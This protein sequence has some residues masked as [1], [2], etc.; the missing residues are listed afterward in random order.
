MRGPDCQHCGSWLPSSW[1][2][3]NFLSRTKTGVPSLS[4]HIVERRLSHEPCIQKH[5]GVGNKWMAGDNTVAQVVGIF[6]R[7]GAAFNAGTEAV[8]G[9]SWNIPAV[10]SDTQL[11]RLPLA[12]PIRRLE[13]LCTS[14]VLSRRDT[15]TD[16]TTTVLIVDPRLSAASR[17]R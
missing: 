6:P 2:F 11:Q 8:L 7:L 1:T 4:T 16:A 13:S 15:C 9:A 3:F 10:I 17:L 14:A 5:D 12:L